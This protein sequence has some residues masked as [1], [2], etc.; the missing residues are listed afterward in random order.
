MRSRTTI[1]RLLDERVAQLA[2]ALEQLEKKE[3][4][5]AALD[6]L[7]DLIDRYKPG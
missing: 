4:E 5:D 7:L 3:K 6:R 1:V 2:Q